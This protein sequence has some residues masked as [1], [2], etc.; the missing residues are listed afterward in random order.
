MNAPL[1]PARAAR[2]AA[3]WITVLF[4]AALAAVLTWR[5]FD[6]YR[7]S[8]P[9]RPLHP[10][11]RRLSPSGL[12]GHGYGMVGTALILTNL[13]YL[14]RRRFAKVV[15]TWAGS[16]KA[17]LNAHVF[18]GLVGS[19]LVVF[20]SAFQLRT[21]IATVTS[22]SLAIVVVTGVVGLYL[23]AL[24]PK[25][26]LKP[27]TERL[28]EIR[29][30]LPGLCG[31]VEAFVRATPLT[32]LR[33]DASFLRTIVT[34]PRWLLEAR[35]RR[36]GLRAAARRDKTV[37]VLERTEPALARAFFAELADLAAGEVDAHAA[38]ALMRSWRSL[39]RFLAVLMIVSVTVHIGVAWY[40]GFRWIFE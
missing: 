4:L 18:T 8:L 23:H 33:H 36:R 35:A 28:A 11:Y 38:A 7:Q 10:D 20:H 24:V 5:G 9:D 13:L 25:S 3:P 1:A 26:G 15:P 39:H 31:E 22:V 17:W 12:V 30:L 6:F 32:S 27:L 16:M 14:V 29:P 2:R 37:R 40:Y 19:L 21:P 34:V